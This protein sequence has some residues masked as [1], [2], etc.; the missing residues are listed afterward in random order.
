[1]T[2]NRERNSFNLV[3]DYKEIFQHLIESDLY[4]LYPSALVKCENPNVCDKMSEF[5]MQLRT[6][7]DRKKRTKHKAQM[8][9][10]IE[11]LFKLFLRNGQNNI[12]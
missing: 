9:A 10:W 7:Q 5:L 8:Y 6:I 3:F 2:T 4:V 1:M 12:A 11:Q